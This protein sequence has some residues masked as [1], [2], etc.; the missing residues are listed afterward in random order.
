MNCVRLPISVVL[1]T[2]GLAIFLEPGRG[3][4][5]EAM[6]AKAS[7]QTTQ[8]TISLNGKPLM[9][10]A[11]VPQ[12]FKP[13]IKEL[14]TTKGYNVL[15]DSPF[16]HL[17]HH[18]LMYGIRVNGINF[19]EET[20]GCGIQKPVETIAPE[21]GQSPAGLPQARISQVI[22]WLAP[23][24]AFLP[25]TNAPALLVEKRTLTLTLD[26]KQQE[27]AVHWRSHFK[28]GTKT[29]VVVLTGATYHGL[30]MRFQKELDAVA[31]HFTPEGK[32]DLG[33]NKQDMSVHT[34]EA[35]EFNAPDHPVTIVLFGHPQ[36]ARGD[37]RFF[38][39]KTPFA[40]LSATQ[41]L[42]REPIVYRRGDEF[43]LN[44]L[45]TL[46]SELKTADSIVERGR[47]WAGLKP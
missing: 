40:Y 32:P 42:D 15:R 45:I 2:F 39:M 7:S 3:H 6:E 11:F 36:N 41:G 29:N 1:I 24:D 18:A 44:Y 9:V 12:K 33:G 25:D 20:P 47:K 14:Y 23:E 13:Y 16:D 19:W 38:S 31:V 5:A 46:C 27:V 4:G 43:E 30:G 21:I 26:E 28:P 34:W 35:V 22:H 8:W 17:H 10:Y 37:A